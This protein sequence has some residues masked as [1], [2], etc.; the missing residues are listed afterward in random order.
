MLIKDYRICEV[1]GEKIHEGYVIQDEYF[2]LKCAEKEYTFEQ[3][4]RLANGDEAYY[5][6]WNDEII[7]NED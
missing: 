1:C 2:C 4:E 5:T 7:R 3:L 6:E